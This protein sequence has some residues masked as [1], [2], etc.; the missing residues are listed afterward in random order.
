MSC[1]YIDELLYMCA[2]VDFDC[3]G[4]VSVYEHENDKFCVHFFGS[5]VLERFGWLN[6]WKFVMSVFMD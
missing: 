6:C 2:R 1:V 3:L 4:L 5:V